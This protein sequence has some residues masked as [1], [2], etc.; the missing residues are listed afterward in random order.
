MDATRFDHLAQ[1]VAGATRRSLLGA[2]TALPLVGGLLALVQNGDLI[3]ID[4]QSNRLQ[5][6]VPEEEIR[7]RQA[8]WTPPALT[9][10]SGLL[11]KYAQTVSS[12]SEGCVTD[13]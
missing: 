9:A 10:H 2:L 11:R 12:A 4:A 6:E 5:L 1:S 3:R 7:R 8:A 13:Q